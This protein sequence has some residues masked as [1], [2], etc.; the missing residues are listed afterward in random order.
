MQEQQ[1]PKYRPCCYWMCSS[2]LLWF[3]GLLLYRV[4]VWEKWFLVISFK[5]FF[6]LSKRPRILFFYLVFYCQSIL[7]AWTKITL[8]TSKRNENKVDL[9]N[10]LKA[11]WSI[12]ENFERHSYMSLNPRLERMIRKVHILNYWKRNSIFFFNKHDTLR[13]MSAH[14][15]EKSSVIW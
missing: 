5:L 12:W 8:A 1:G 13:H 9:F 2:R 6:F 14:S 10:H 7:L 15:N 3:C 11:A 4:N